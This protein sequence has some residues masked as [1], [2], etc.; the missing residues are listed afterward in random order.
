VDAF[1]CR[2][3][4]APADV[5][6]AVGVRRAVPFL[7]AAALV[8]VL[9]VGLMQA[10]GD[11]ADDAG[12]GPTLTE[13][14]QALA[15]AP[16]PLAALYERANA[17][18]PSSVD[19]FEGELRA[20]RGHPVVVNAWASWCGP[21]KLE[22]PFFQRAAA[23]LG[24]DTAFLALNV[25]DNR[26]SAEKFLRGTPVPY[27]SLEDDGA[28]LREAAPGTRGLPVT[29]FYDKDGKRAFVHQGGYRSEADLVEDIERYAGA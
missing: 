22:F 28:I 1:A 2:D 9:V 15:D 24:K 7:A 3:S 16:P 19:D 13:A 5:C 11:D 18:E 14:Q 4:S 25:E 21:C 27:P 20:L 12:T 23:R 6:E 26:E 17:I 8:A 29:I 10:G